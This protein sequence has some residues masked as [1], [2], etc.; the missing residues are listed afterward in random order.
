[1]IE[2]LGRFTAQPS[3]DLTANCL[4]AYETQHHPM[5]E[6]AAR[7]GRD[8]EDGSRAG[9]ETVDF[10]KLPHYVR[11]LAAHV[12]TI[13]Q[14]IDDG[15][16]LRRLLDTYRVTAVRPSI[17]APRPQ[18]D[19]HTTLRGILK[20]LLPA[21]DERFG[22]MLVHLER[23]NGQSGLE[24]CIQD[25]LSLAKR[26]KSVIHCEVQVLEHFYHN[27]LRFAGNDPSIGCSKPSWLCCRLYFQH[28]PLQCAQVD[29]HNRLYINWAPKLLP[30][31]V[32]DQEWK[33][34]R[35]VLGEIA[36]E[37]GNLAVRGLERVGICRHDSVNFDS[38][39][40]STV[41]WDGHVELYDSGSET[42]SDDS[43]EPGGALL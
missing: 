33:V 23:I 5:L 38:L 24:A 18:A 15:R 19:I 34:Q 7:L 3:G 37:L 35:H 13:T 41:S 11:R 31:G 36:H 22:M 27:K 28:H 39:D 43:D 16:R 20:R 26:E 32:K 10:K 9:S 6:T 25:R 29:A 21:G 1:V 30:D 40:G 2:F 14:V 42:A 12:R 8:P 4:V 17:P